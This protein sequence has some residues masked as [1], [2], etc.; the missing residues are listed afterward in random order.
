M[1]KIAIPAI[2][3]VLCALPM[4]GQTANTGAI[5]GT[6][7]DPSG[8]LVPR[9]AV[10][11]NS[12]ATQEER[13]LTTD[14]DGNF[15]VPFLTPGNYELT[16]RA[17]GFEP[18]VLKSV[19]VQITEVSR[20]KLQLTISGEKK[21][22]TVSAK[23][24]LV[25][26]ESAT[27]GRVIDQET[28]VHLPLVDRNFTEILGLTAGTNTDVVDATQLGAG[29]QE[30]R[31]NGARSGDNNFMFNGVDAN[32]Y[33]SN[34]TEVT[35]FGGAGIAIPAP[36][37]IQE[38]KVQNSLY[39]AQYGRGGG[40]NVNVETKSGTA[41]FHGNVYYFGRNEVLDANNFFAN[42]TG[43]PR[44]EFRRSQPGGTLGGPFRRPKNS[45]FFLLSYQAT[46]DINAASLDS[47]V[48]SL[49]LPP[50]PLVRT[51]A[52]LGVVFGG[53]TGALGGVAVAPDG[54]NINPV[55]LNLLNAKNP[56]GAFVIPSPQSSGSGVNYT[57]ALPGH[58]NEDQFNTNA[59]VNLRKADRLSIKFFFSRSN[60]AIPFFGA[61]VPGFPALRAFG[62]RNL[63]ISETHPF[64]SQ[65]INQFRFG[66]SRNAGQ[67][68][69]GGTLTDEEVGIN[70][71]SGTQ[72]GIPQIEVLGA[73]E[74]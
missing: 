25:Q 74:L 4:H 42:A 68:V 22:I 15:S 60:Q 48:R 20:L 1:W 23:P 24:P 51:P 63:S 45:P 50:I 30:I 3:V 27:L 19:Q 57:A 65:T 66:F 71:P 44:G 5:A 7:S 58:Y 47:S 13:D 61:T 31:A 32:S 72:E 67:G 54:S 49:S 64:S 8:A 12:Q 28:V 36:D 43:V 11:V 2:A 14:A 73:F 41:E 69:A 40:A 16:V 29:S 52:S 46:R 6:V 34:I 35:P 37:T 59:D 10:V 62:N 17:P 26:T 53:Q 70:S 56:D 55:A 21:Q 9:A 39:D 38:F 33:A 18:L